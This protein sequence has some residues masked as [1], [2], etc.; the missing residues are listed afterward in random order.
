MSY[1]FPGSSGGCGKN[2]PLT[3]SF[4]AS[5]ITYHSIDD[6]TSDNVLEN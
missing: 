1:I 6:L 5:V 4:A 3:A 2:D